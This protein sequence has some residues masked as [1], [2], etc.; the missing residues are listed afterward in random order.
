MKLD[1]LKTRLMLDSRNEEERAERRFYFIGLI[2]SVL[3]TV[4]SFAS[5][6]TGLL[7][8]AWIFPTLVILALTQIVVHL[9]VFLHIDLSRQ[10]RED[11][12]LLLFTILLLSIMAFGTL[13]IM[14]SLSA[15]M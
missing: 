11:L 1:D 10:K 2:L 6:M 9:R 13:W 8:R 15:R 14:A 7:P 3:L 5:V 4:A 12:Q